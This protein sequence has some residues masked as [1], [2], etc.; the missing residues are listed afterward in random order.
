MLPNRPASNRMTGKNGG[1]WAARTPDHLIKSL[2]HYGQI[3]DFINFLAVTPVASITTMRNKVQLIPA[4]VR[5][6]SY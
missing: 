6:C 3:F 2:V 1:A 5:Q 4:I